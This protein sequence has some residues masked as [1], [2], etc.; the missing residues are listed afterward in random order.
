VGWKPS[1]TYLDDLVDLDVI[2]LIRNGHL[3]L[4]FL[5]TAITIGIR[6]GVGVGGA[7]VPLVVGS[8][9]VGL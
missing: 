1:L 3:A 6:V 7:V 4:S 2:S 5:D 9:G 8:R